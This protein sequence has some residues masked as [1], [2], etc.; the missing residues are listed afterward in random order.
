MMTMTTTTT[1]VV[2][3]MMTMMMS[4]LCQY[5][6]KYLIIIFYS[7]CKKIYRPTFPE[8]IRETRRVV[9]ILNT[10]KQQRT[11]PFYFISVYYVTIVTGKIN[12]T[13]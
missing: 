8:C 7:S 10:H 9:C 13:V 5:Y 11:L 1:M 12:I 2:V 4:Y 3:M 6:N